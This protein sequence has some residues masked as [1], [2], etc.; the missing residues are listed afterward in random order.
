V[1]KGF[2][3]LCEIVIDSWSNSFLDLNVEVSGHAKGMEVREVVSQDE[4]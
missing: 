2:F 1:V 3:R 4:L